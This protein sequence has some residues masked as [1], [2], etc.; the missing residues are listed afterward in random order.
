MSKI[1]GFKYCVTLFL[2]SGCTQLQQAPLIYSSQS[3]VG[4]DVSST[5]AANPG[6]AISLGIRQTDFAYVPVAVSPASAPSSGNAEIKIIRADYGQNFGETTVEQRKSRIS[7]MRAYDTA[8]DNAQ[9]AEVELNKC[10]DDLENSKALM[11]N[12]IS[13]LSAINL[14]VALPPTGAAP[15]ASAA[16]DVTADYQTKLEARER[17]IKDSLLPALAKLPDSLASKSI[18]NDGIAALK[19][20]L[21]EAQKSI[22]L[23]IDTQTKKVDENGDK[24]I[25]AKNTR[26]SAKADLESFE[27][28]MKTDKNDALSVFGSFNS[29]ASGAASAPSAGLAVGKV[30]STGL[31]SQNLTEAAKI[32]AV[33]ACISSAASV[34]S[35]AASGASTSERVAMITNISAACGKSFNPP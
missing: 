8:I 35:Q 10:K 13:A 3:I 11:T 6:F 20:K 23:L 5:S 32:S 29:A 27:Q 30:F 18:T 22:K 24:F 19:G 12:V 25:L 33:S 2:L 28:T 21:T 16:S 4:A 15:P 34:V 7:K 1:V 31:A 26:A 9:K 14:V 17:I